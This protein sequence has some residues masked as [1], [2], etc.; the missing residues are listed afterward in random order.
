MQKRYNESICQNIT[1]A[2]HFFFTDCVKLEEFRASYLINNNKTKANCRKI[3]DGLRS[4][5]NSSINAIIDIDNCDQAA[6]QFQGKLNCEA[7]KFVSKSILYCEYDND[8]KVHMHVH[9]YVL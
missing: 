5:I 8:K 1:R 3:I 7:L 9:T 2:Q 4:P 6:M